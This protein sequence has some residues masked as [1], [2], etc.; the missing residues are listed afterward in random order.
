[1]D[2]AVFAA[3]AEPNRRRILELLGE[4]PR[5]VGEVASAVGLRQP[6]ATKHLQALERAGLVAGTSLGRRRIYAL[7]REAFVALRN[8]AEALAAAVSD[9]DDALLAYER[10]VRR[11][12]RRA[13][14]GVGTVPRAMQLTRGFATPP[15]ALWTWWTT[16][17]RVREWWAP[18]HFTVADAD[19]APRVGGVLNVVLAEGDGTEHRAEGRFLALDEP[20]SLTFE[21]SPLGSDGQPL[22]RSTHAVA[23]DPSADGPGTHLVM[24]IA[25]DGIAP[26]AEPALAGVEIGWDQTLARLARL[27]ARR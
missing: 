7:R 14:A 17:A 11:E 21:M 22:F 13:A 25:I 26:G 5:S 1:M 12:Q 2:P 27:V 24:A 3:L 19:V 9:D 6:T 15:A 18:E 10:A 8:W 20:R 16:E 23:F 4:S